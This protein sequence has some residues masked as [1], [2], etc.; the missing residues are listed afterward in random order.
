MDVLSTS[1]INKL[2]TSYMQSQEAK[3]VK[4]V[5]SNKA[6][7]EKL[8]SSYSTLLTKLNSLQTVLGN[9]G[10][11][12]STSAFEE[13]SA[14]FSIA[15]ALSASAGASAAN[16]SYNISVDQLAR[17]D[18]AASKTFTA[19][20][21]LGGGEDGTYEFSIESGST[22]ATISV[23]LLAGDTYEEAL[24]KIADAVNADATASSI[25]SASAFR[26]TTD[27][28]QLTFTAKNTGEDNAL[29]FANVSGKNMFGNNQFLDID[30][31][32]RTAPTGTDGGYVY[33]LTDL[34]AKLTL[35]G[36][37]IER[38]TNVIDDLIDDV[39]LTLSGTTS[40]SGTLEVAN[41]V[42]SMTD[43]ID[44]FITAFNEA[45]QY[46]KNNVYADK[47]TGTRGI[48]TGESTARQMLSTFI[49][50]ATADIRGD[51]SLEQYLSEGDVGL[52]RL[53]DIGI[54]FD[55]T[56]G[57][58]ITDQELLETELADR[59]SEVAN[60]FAVD[61]GSETGLAVGLYDKIDAL[62]GVDGT[63]ARLQESYSSQISR[64]ADRIES[65]QS[66]INGSAE[67]L[68]SQYERL[69]QQLVSLLNS[70]SMFSSFSQGMY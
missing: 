5:E 27:E 69:Q 50:G 35:N 70:Q 52:T 16:A 9:L 39:T 21:A 38:S 31:T 26:P 18:V 64:A 4:P 6:K 66:R 59:P 32:T 3:L 63:I 41:D 20:D 68:R 34:N 33:D 24:Q 11:S 65:L 12:G 61:D 45:Y 44:S 60:L 25:V 13:K 58:K 15:D 19:A 14:T 57:L 30:N 36:V 67:N 62:T 22:T 1:G 54:E 43:E 42:E 8:N 40:A 17:A 7:Y 53:L 37:A 47:T 48:F 51:V 2:V 10:G 49:E 29:V 55:P 23:E 28:A 46:V 56:T